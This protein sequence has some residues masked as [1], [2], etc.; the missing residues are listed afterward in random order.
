[1]A[2]E[3][4]RRNKNVQKK[5]IMQKKLSANFGSLKHSQGKASWW[6]RL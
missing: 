2:Y 4:L 6:Q 3:H 5:G 1:M